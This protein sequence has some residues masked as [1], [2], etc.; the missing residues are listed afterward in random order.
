MKQHFATLGRQTL[1]YGVSG[2]AL[3]AV[4]LI[5]LP[6]FA[7]VFTPA[8]YGVLEVVTVGVAALMLVADLSLTSAS[9][10]SFFDYSDEQPDERR[11]VLASAIATALAVA[12]LIAAA[13]F[14]VREPLAEWLLDGQG[15]SSLLALA[16]LSIPLTVA[17]SMLR[18]VMRLHFRAWHYA[19]SATISA[20][21]AGGLGA[22]LVLWTSAGVDGVVLGIVA[23]NATAVAYGLAVAGR[24]AVGR[25]SKSELRTMLAFGLPLI[26][27]AAALWG[28]A[29]LDRVML[30]RL[31]DLAEV[32]EYAVAA[33]F[34]TVVML[35][36]TAFGLA[37]SPFLL[38]LWSSDPEGEKQLRARTLTYVTV[39]L[40]FASLTLGLFARELIAVV[41]PD[42]EGAH[43]V[44][45]VL[46]LGVA[47]FGVANV[48]L[49]AFVLA[50][51]TRLIAIYSLAAV[52]VNL[53]LTLVLIP[54]LGGMGAA[55]AT[56]GGYATLAVGYYVHGQRIY[57]TPYTVW[58]PTVTLLLAAVFMPLGL[59]SPGLGSV[60]L[61]IAGLGLFL[62]SLL[63]LR[64]LDQ[65][66]VS[67]F[68]KTVGLIV[69][70]RRRLLSET[71]SGP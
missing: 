28:V 12:T 14:L 20:V 46:C 44:V 33:R 22:G 67:E 43:E 45:G 64:V 54:P 70:R 62:V 38:S 17:A 51:R 30:S 53:A 23:G 69:R 8:E 49:A 50:R 55:L 65:A 32:G 61:K 41:A 48:V 24:D 3:Q 9:Q 5:T 31:A 58:K 52:A 21:I 10:R 16:A 37:Y 39:A 60:A 71:T 59:L 42:F 15:Y 34:G 57:P 2:T 26:P 29:F 36:V 13:V 4:G 18:E 6:V 40:A 66:E 63:G 27:A 68:T 1:I 25:L 7:R 56:V 19:V 11:S 47:L 35:G